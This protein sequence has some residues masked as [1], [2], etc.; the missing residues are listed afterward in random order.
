MLQANPLLTQIQLLDD[1]LVTLGSGV[2]EIIK[3]TAAC[4][5]HPEKVIQLRQ[6]AQ[7]VD[8]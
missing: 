8:R 1:R 3:E 6:K 2:L 5:N 7:D 4:G